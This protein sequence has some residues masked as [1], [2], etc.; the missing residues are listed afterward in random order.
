MSNSEKYY[1]NIFWITV[2][3]KINPELPERC[4]KFY[5]M[6]RRVCQNEKSA[7]LCKKV[8][9]ELVSQCVEWVKKYKKDE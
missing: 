4:K 3:D 6:S 5:E 2:M 8:T 1:L 7:A 9:D